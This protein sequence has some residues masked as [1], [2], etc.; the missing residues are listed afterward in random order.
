[1]IT[2]FDE[3]QWPDLTKFR[4]ACLDDLC[5][6]MFRIAELAHHWYQNENPESISTE[7]LSRIFQVQNCSSENNLQQLEKVIK[8]SLDSSRLVTDHTSSLFA[9]R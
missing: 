9:R 8:P 7:K 2:Q 4:D 6:E 3:S 5:G 1:M